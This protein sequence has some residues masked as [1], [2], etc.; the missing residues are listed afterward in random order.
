M[1]HPI[2][3]HGVEVEALVDAGH[4]AHELS[5]GDPVRAPAG[6]LLREPHNL[7]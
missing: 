5:P 3:H 1:H 4:G 2:G 6:F 7:P